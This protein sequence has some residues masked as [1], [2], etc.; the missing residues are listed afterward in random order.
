MSKVYR[1]FCALRSFFFYATYLP[2][3]GFF[4]SLGFT[5]GQVMPYRLRHNLVTLGATVTN[6]WLWLW[7]GVKVEISGLENIPKAPC[8]VLAKHQSTWETYQLQRTFRPV[9]TILKKELLDIPIFGWGLARLHPVAI[10]R[11]NPRKAMKQIMLQGEQRLR[12]GN[13]I[14][15]YPEGTRVD[16]GQ[17][18][19]YA[20]SGAAL[21]I[22]AG[23][24]I[25]PVA[26]NAGT[27]WSKRRFIKYP[28]TIKMLIGAPICTG[29]GDSK[30]LTEQVRKWIE[31]RQREIDGG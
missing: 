28:G 30:A 29:G 23:V 24:P 10:D 8:V 11:S 31:S 4:A 2:C 14:V 3:I 1:A 15:I 5:I 16:P 13:N 7:C 9:S 22:A 26:L 27:Y 25:V 20:R 12:E 21:A 18:G 6:F 17:Q 19:K